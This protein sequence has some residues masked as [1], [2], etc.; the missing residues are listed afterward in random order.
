MWLKLRE[1]RQMISK[2]SFFYPFLSLFSSLG[3]LVCCTLPAI[4]VSLGAGA[5]LAS[6][7][8]TF[9][10]LIWLSAHKLEVFSIAGICLILG[11]VMQYKA[12]SMSCPVDPLKAKTCMKLRR[13]NFWL[14]ILSVL[15][16]LVGAFFAF[17]AKYFL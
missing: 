14:Y 11:G 16:F 8:T 6:L 10:Q 7:V 15:I 3:T 17:G 12:R 2:D 9:P 4:F 5:T 1:V 13:I